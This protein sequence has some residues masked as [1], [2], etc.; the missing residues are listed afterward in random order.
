MGVC[1]HTYTWTRGESIHLARALRPATK[2]RT[3][4]LSKIL[5]ENAGFGPEMMHL[6]AFSLDLLPILKREK[7]NHTKKSKTSSTPEKD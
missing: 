5:L 6:P 1:V 3:R 2:E 4:V 7:K